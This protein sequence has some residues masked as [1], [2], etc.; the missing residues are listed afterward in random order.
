[1]TTLFGQVAQ[2]Y[3]DVRPGYPGDITAAIAAY[4][5]DADGLAE[6]GPGT[7]KGTE[8]LAGLRVPM[9][10]I[11]PD[12]LMAALLQAKFPQATITISTFE[13]WTPPP[14]GTALLC[15]AMAWHWLDPQTRNRRAFDT[16]RPGGALAVFGHKYAFADP[17]H[18]Q[19]VDDAFASCG[20]AKQDKAQ[21]WF[22]DDIVASGLW[23]DVR[24]TVFTRDWDCTTER[25]LQLHQTFSPFLRRSPAEQDKILAALRHAVDGL[26]GLIRLRLPTTLVL[27]RRP[28]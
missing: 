23:S 21:Q 11:E 26:G 20:V 25:Y 1:M 8:V 19:A 4:A 13:Q 7:G 14:G 27:A 12:P 16:L 6:L 3:D 2:S 18:E 22:H 17:A 5:P 15:C 10:C 28:A 24:C 9:T